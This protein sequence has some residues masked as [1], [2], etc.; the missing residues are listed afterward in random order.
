MASFHPRNI[1]DSLAVIVSVKTHKS[2]PRAKGIVPEDPKALG[3]ADLLEGS[4]SR[5][6][7]F[8]E[9]VR[10][11]ERLF[12]RKAI[13]I[14]RDRDAA[15]DAVQE[16]FVRI[17]I[18][19]HK[20]EK[21]E[22]ASFSSWGYKILVNQC[23]TAHTK[24]ARHQAVSFDAEPEFSEAVPDKA[25]LDAMEKRMTSDY[26]M[27]LISKLP[28]FLARA[29]KLYFIEG[30]AQKEIAKQEGVSNEVV[31][32]RIYRA[33]RELRKMNLEFAPAQVPVPTRSP[34]RS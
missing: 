24:R 3:D 25:S 8:E 32:Q 21:Q 27:S 10:R 26:V 13:A 15:A 4:A 20:F 14:L 16:T 12:M 6:A 19:S 11:Y 9:I 7:L 2:Q 31:R 5:P 33:K 30:M 1:F 28:A 23:Y 29:V 22:G 34:K 18:A 17:Y